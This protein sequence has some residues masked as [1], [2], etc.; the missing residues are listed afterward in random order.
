MNDDT[1]LTL[2]D[3]LGGTGGT[4]RGTNRGTKSGTSAPHD[5][6]RRRPP[7]RTERTITMPVSTARPTDDSSPTAAAR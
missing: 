1:A 5:S 3:G 2:W 7:Q 4:D 6:P